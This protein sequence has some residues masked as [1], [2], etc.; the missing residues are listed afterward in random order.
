VTGSS[1]NW[2]VKVPKVVLVNPSRS[3][4]GFSF[5]TPRWLFVIAQATPT[6]LVGNPVLVNESI[7]AFDP[8]MVDRGD[9][10]G[11]GIGTVNCRPAYDVIR[12][13]KTRG[14]TV[15]VGGVHATLV[16]EEP[17]QYGADSVV[18]GNGDLAWT[19]AV[20]DAL[21][22]RLARRYVGGRVD[23][24]DLLKARWDLMEAGKYLFPT[25]QT[26]AGCPENCS[27][28]SV[29]VSDGRKPRQ[30]LA[31]KV[32]EEVNELYGLGY[33]VILLADD[34]FAPATLGRIAREP[35]AQKRKEL[36]QI[37]DER[38]RFF[39]EYD[40]RVPKDI[41]AFSQITS[42][43][44]S[45]E[46]YLSALVKKMR[47]RQALVGV[48]SFSAEGLE[49]ANKQWN[50]SGQGMVRAIQRIQEEGIV[51]LSSLICGLESDTVETLRR[52]REQALTS[53]TLMAQFALYNPYPGT[54]DYYEMQQDRQ[55]RDSAGYTPKHRT[56]LVLDKFW[57]SDAGPAEVI[58]HANLSAE[59][60][61]RENR[62][63]WDAFY[64]LTAIVRRTRSGIARKWPF[65]GRVTYVILS[66]VFRRVY[67]GNGL[68]ADIVHKR[69]I[70]LLTK[71]FIKVGVHCYSWFC[72]GGVRV[73]MGARPV[74]HDRSLA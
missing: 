53:G 48:E 46:E 29:W 6:D 44:A 60:L 15:I 62:L 12:Q 56:R 45:D 4:V 51:V 40:R 41:Y 72:G 50:P 10:V 20:R 68:V 47:I 19:Q 70:G 61:L 64:S 37:R 71:A 16:P 38:L 1:I 69:K 9:I 26:V 58:Q 33:R 22:G 5:I 65:M 35:S 7:E 43:I 17:A 27:F 67:A 11:I 36:E 24:D 32:I 49:S 13:A 73:R 30:R 34:N 23:G 14:A 21:D 2:R 3:T 39:D 66:L 54:V 25:V 63:S 57:L 74:R 31:E 59:D 52:M 8:A 55:R 18:T 28:C 42:E